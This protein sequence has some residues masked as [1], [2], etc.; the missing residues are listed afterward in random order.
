MFHV[1]TCIRVDHAQTFGYY[2]YTQHQQST[3]QIN[4]NEIIG[5][6]YNTYLVMD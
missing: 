1:P 2:H 5:W 3:V 4:W 6:D